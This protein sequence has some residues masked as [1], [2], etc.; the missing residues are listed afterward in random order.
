[1]ITENSKVYEATL[2]P[3]WKTTEIM[4]EFTQLDDDNNYV[5][6]YM[7]LS[8]WNHSFIIGPHTRD[9]EFIVDIHCNY[10]QI[11]T[12]YGSGITL[13]EMKSGDFGSFRSYI[14]KLFPTAK[15]FN[16]TIMP[17]KDYYFDIPFLFRAQSS[18]QRGKGSTAGGLINYGATNYYSL[19]GIKITDAFNSMRKGKTYYTIIYDPEKEE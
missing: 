1:M 7:R 19:V 14:H 12:G 2:S 10:K 5:Y 9:F 16:D 13:S 8:L 15:E 17:Y 6:D 11:E 4:D 3:S 18:Y